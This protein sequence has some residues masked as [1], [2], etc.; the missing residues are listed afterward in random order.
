MLLRGASSRSLAAALFFAALFLEAAAPLRAQDEAAAVSLVVLD[1]SRA[2]Q[3]NNAALFL[4]KFDG[5]SMPRFDDLR[6][7]VLALTAQRTIASS[8]EIGPL[9]EADGGPAVTVDWLL[10]LTPLFEP[11]PVETRREKLSLRFVKRKGKWRI[12]ALEP[13]DFFR[14]R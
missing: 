10:Q 14:S 9:R 7:R 13:A 5:R 2:L 12:A 1:A 3:A 8:V 11:G 4:S 6:V